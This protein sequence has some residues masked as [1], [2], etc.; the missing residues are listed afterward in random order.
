MKTVDGRVHEG[1]RDLVLH[2]AVCREAG[3]AVVGPP[4]TTTL[5]VVP[6][7]EIRT[8]A[9]DEIRWALE[10]DP[11]PEYVVLTAVRA[12][13][14]VETGQ[15]VSKTEA[16]GWAER[17]TPDARLVAGALARQRGGVADVPRQAARSFARRVLHVL[18]PPE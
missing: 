12:W 11:P 5:G 10:H 15:I 3:L 18:D 14:Y 16:G 7:E 6:I 8:A 1:D 4:P 2:L 9:I 17:R 13:C